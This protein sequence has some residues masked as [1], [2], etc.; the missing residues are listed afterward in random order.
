MKAL[1][2]DLSVVLDVE[3]RNVP[4][5]LALMLTATALDLLGI[6]L[7]APFVIAALN[8]VDTAA[9]QSAVWTGL[10]IVGAFGMRALAGFHLQRSMIRFSDHHRATLMA[11]LLERYLVQPWIFHL[12]RNQAELTN[13]LLYEVALY[14]GNVLVAALRVVSDLL[15][16]IALGLFLITLNLP[17][18][19]ALGAGIGITVV[20]VNLA[21]RSLMREN[22]ERVVQ[23]YQRLVETLGNSLSARKQTRVLGAERLF[24]SRVQVAGREQA[25]ATA[26][27]NAL[28]TV[29]RSALELALVILMMGAALWAGNSPESMSAAVATLGTFGVASLRLLPAASSLSNHLNLLRANRKVLA[30]LAAD[31]RLPAEHV[32]QSQAPIA[33]HPIGSE[34]TDK[35]ALP[36]I[37][38]DDV[39]FR[40]PGGERDV[41][42]DLNL[43]I[44]AGQCCGI[45]GASGSG[46]STLG[47]LLLGL[48]QPTKGRLLVD[49]LPFTSETE[50][51]TL[52]WTRRCAYIPQDPCL[53]NDTLRINVTLNEALGE[54]VDQRV[55]AALKQAALGDLVSQLPQ[56]LEEPLGDNGERLSGGQR[57][58]LAIARA[59]YHEREF[60]VF[61]EATSALDADTEQ[62]IVAAIA[63]LQGRATVLVITHREA[64][65]APCSQVFSMEQGALKPFDREVVA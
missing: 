26:L 25:E 63:E 19:L 12:K 36:A 61:D 33:V 24:A 29:P 54:E 34:N 4:W 59:F 15:V 3:G 44:P 40:Y 50:G 39:S 6:S 42:S 20:A 46:K 64:L 65:L 31:L 35:R 28:Q 23:R 45:V 48:L 43:N 51:D 10:A 22:A 1:L 14:C 2:K 9:R 53:F 55:L 5:V 49:K 58:R 17:V 37:S 16:L 38:L 8:G 41:L 7:I 11:R 52:A 30:R 13:T 27:Q 62:E 21:T 47:D 56:G 57:Q 60:L 18:A 32:D